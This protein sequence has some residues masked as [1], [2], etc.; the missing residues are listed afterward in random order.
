MAMVSTSP[1]KTRKFLAF[2]LMLRSS[3]RLRYSSRET[4]LSI[5]IALCISHYVSKEYVPQMAKYFRLCVVL[6]GCPI[7]PMWVT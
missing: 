4:T 2:T 7:C 3:N 6:L 1:W 5:K